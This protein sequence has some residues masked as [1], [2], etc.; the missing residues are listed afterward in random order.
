MNIKKHKPVDYLADNGQYDINTFNYIK[1]IYAK[2][3]L[4]NNV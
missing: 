1:N 3:F 4:N 2:Y